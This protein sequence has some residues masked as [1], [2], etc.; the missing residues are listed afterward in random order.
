[1]GEKS[2]TFYNVENGQ[3]VLLPLEDEHERSSL[4]I[5]GSIQIFLVIAIS[6]QAH[7]LLAKK[8]PFWTQV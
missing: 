2:F 7:V 6:D 5:P 1:M 8:Q 4:L 3:S